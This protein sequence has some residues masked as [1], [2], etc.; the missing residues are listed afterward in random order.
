MPSN[1]PAALALP[2]LL[3][4]ALV[5]GCGEDPAATAPAA[6]PEP[7]SA[8]APADTATT[9]KASL[10]RTGPIVNTTCPTCD[11]AVT[12]EPGRTPTAVYDGKTYGFCCPNCRKTFIDAP[13]RYV[14]EASADG[15]HAGHDHDHAGHDHADHDH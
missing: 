12:D 9:V 7:A 8:D 6:G 14:K 3:A 1:R 13:A 10:G 4:F 11:T 5:A 15:D 2:L